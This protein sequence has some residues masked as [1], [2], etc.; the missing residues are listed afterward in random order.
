MQGG[1]LK[2]ALSPFNAHSLRRISIVP[3]AKPGV[4]Q[5]LQYDKSTI[6][7]HSYSQGGHG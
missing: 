4:L 2:P 3:V 5:Q 6:A 1:G 7:F